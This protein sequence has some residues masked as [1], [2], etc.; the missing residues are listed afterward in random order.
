MIKFTRMPGFIIISLIL[1][2]ISS[3][4]D[5]DPF[6]SSSGVY[7]VRVTNSLPEPIVV[8][9]GPANYGSIASKETTGYMQ[10]SEGENKILLNGEVF[11]G[12]PAEF[13]VGFPGTHRWTY[14][15]GENSWGFISDDF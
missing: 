13:A 10:V 15:F 4:N 6:G 7:L 1:L 2:L 9:I 3:C 11:K 5:N 14:E 12:S 8:I